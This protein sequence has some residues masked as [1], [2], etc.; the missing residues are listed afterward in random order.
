M[1]LLNMNMYWYYT[2]I[3]RTLQEK[4]TDSNSC[5]YINLHQRYI[6]L[7]TYN[8]VWFTVSHVSCD[9]YFGF[10]EKQKEGML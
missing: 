3:Y 5:Y 10:D 1:L 8:L 4:K 9:I 7:S 6:V 2:V